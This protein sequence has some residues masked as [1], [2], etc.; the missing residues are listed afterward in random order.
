M[1]ILQRVNDVVALA[2]LVLVLSLVICG[3]QWV[4]SGT[5]S[6]TPA[7][8]PLGEAISVIGG[9]DARIYEAREYACG[10]FS[11][12]DIL[13]G[14]YFLHWTP[15]GFQL[16]FNLPKLPAIGRGGVI[17]IV[18][19]EN[20]LQRTIVDANPGHSFRGDSMQTYLRMGQL[21][22]TQVV[23]SLLNQD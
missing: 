14:Q 16:I 5:T 4:H 22:F 23:S 2:I 3:C 21:L 19:L 11:D 17:K 13:T 18:S 20:F 12:P 1:Y 8:N 7:T 9:T 10:P 15:D 6:P